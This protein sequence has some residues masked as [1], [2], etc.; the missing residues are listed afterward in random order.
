MPEQS[1]ARQWF[2]LLVQQACKRRKPQPSFARS[3]SRRRK[4]APTSGMTHV[5]PALGRAP[6]AP[7][8]TSHPDLPFDARGLSRR[9]TLHL[10]VLRRAARLE[11]ALRGGGA[12]LGATELRSLRS[13]TAMLQGPFLA[14]LAD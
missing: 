1:G 14:H 7:G 4:P 8:M 12:R 9:R 5:I 13:F 2:Q 6:D 10:R 11:R 3:R